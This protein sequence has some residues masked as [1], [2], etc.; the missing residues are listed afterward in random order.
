MYRFIMFIFAWQIILNL[1][2]SASRAVIF[3]R[4]INFTF[5]LSPFFV[6][7]TSTSFTLY[8]IWIMAIWHGVE[9]FHFWLL[10]TI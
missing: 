10:Y 2:V 6:Y 8:I 3:S 1:S 5:P 7:E 9:H 4:L